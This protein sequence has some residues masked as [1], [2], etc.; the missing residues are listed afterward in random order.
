[1]M[2]VAHKQGWNESTQLYMALQF[3]E[4]HGSHQ[5]FEDYLEEQAAFENGQPIEGD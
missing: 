3:V 2:D 5:E 1:M 4:V